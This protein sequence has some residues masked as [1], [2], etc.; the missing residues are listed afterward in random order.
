MRG[1]L[2]A[3]NALWGSRQVGVFRT[4][5]EKW[6]TECMAPKKGGKGVSVIVWDC[7]WGRNCGAF[8]PFVVQS[9]N[10]RVDLKWLECLVLPVVQRI[11]DAIS[12]AVFQ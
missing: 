1:L 6:K 4:P 7:F 12:D 3:R 10:A 2:G 5:S 9:V 8:C 11:N